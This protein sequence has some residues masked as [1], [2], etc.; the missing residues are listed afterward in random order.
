MGKSKSKKTDAVVTSEAPA[1]GK[2]RSIESAPFDPAL[3]ALF[4]SSAGPVQTGQRKVEKSR[5]SKEGAGSNLTTSIG[6]DNTA[7]RK[8]GEL[9]ADDGDSS[10]APTRENGV[11]ATMPV[12][13]VEEAEEID[14]RPKKRR[15]RN[16]E[17]DIEGVY[18]SKLVREEAKEQSQR[19]RGNSREA[20]VSRNTD[21]QDRDELEDAAESDLDS[22][23]EDISDVESGLDDSQQEAVSKHE[24]LTGDAA[25][26]K[27]ET[28]KRTVFL[29]NVS[30]T[31]I[32]SKSAKKT[33]L[34]H[35]KS[36]L[37][38]KA[39]EKVESLRFRSTA[40]ASDAGPKR[41]AFAKKELM[42][43]TMKST[44][45][46]V[47][48][49]SLAAARK[50]ASRLNGT[51]VLD[52]HLRVDNVA[53][54]AAIDHKRCVFVGNLS[55]VDVAQATAQDDN[56]ED[57]IKQR[58]AKEP[59][60]VEEGLWR[61]F[62]KCGKIESVRVVRDKETRISKGFAYVQFEDENGVESALGLDNKRFPPLL[63]RT[64]RV[65]RAKR[66]M[67]KD[68]RTR[69]NARVGGPGRNTS[70]GRYDKRSASKRSSAESS[71]IVFEGHRATPKT[72]KDKMRTKKAE[73]PTNRS[74][75]RGAVFKAGGRK[76]KSDDR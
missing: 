43:E 18:L 21:P 17:D 39:G 37:D 45:C 25:A 76:R 6:V 51:V 41:A 53:H 73:K 12:N 67:K 71:N 27:Q 4:A 47:V 42:D 16:E 46:Y 68:K 15:R 57:K 32:T 49:S 33:L 10:P 38:A 70:Q 8:S 5:R 29:G 55:F 75:R 26:R 13:E 34:L 24:A 69:E 48:L 56:G 74:A 20:G 60:D 11:L 7:A 54:P 1:P 3:E 22:D 23:L 40:F 65:M 72:S 52:R 58:R 61:S 36:A 50:V 63:P 19:M 66:I 35:I 44:N 14:T 28:D 64:L 31:A 9:E 30:I 2:E 62:G 59:A